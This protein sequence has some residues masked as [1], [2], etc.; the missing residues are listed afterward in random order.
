MKILN[1]VIPSLTALAA[2]WLAGYFIGR[3]QK[4]PSKT[5]GTMFI[6]YACDGAPE[7]YL[8]DLDANFLKKPS[9]IIRLKVVCVKDNGRK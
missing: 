7:L 1:V 2:G 5:S 3:K 4:A 6:N 9:G 8:S